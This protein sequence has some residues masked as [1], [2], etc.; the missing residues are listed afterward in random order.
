M[1]VYELIM[2]NDSIHDP[3]D[4][5]AA[6]RDVSLQ[7]PPESYGADLFM[8]TTDRFVVDHRTEEEEKEEGNT[9]THKVEW[10]ADSYK[11][12]R[13]CLRHSSANCSI[14]EETM[15]GETTKHNATPEAA[16]EKK[17]TNYRINRP[18][19][20]VTT[21]L[22]VDDNDNDPIDTAAVQV[23]RAPRYCNPQRTFFSSPSSVLDQR[24]SFDDSILSGQ[25]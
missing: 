4:V 2:E 10:T 23:P 21:G 6:A 16:T 18:D 8:P 22:H 11:R 17:E 9:T 15:R 19:P 12:R 3:S 24:C 5:A 20:I 7:R 14:A 1:A 13:R 25:T